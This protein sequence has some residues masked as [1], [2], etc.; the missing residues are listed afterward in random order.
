M[1]SLWYEPVLSA[2]P[3]SMWNRVLSSSECCMVVHSRHKRTGHVK[4]MAMTSNRILIDHLVMTYAISGPAS[5][6]NP[7]AGNTRRSCGHNCSQDA[8][9]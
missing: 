6:T 8:Q 2:T 7:W 4:Q 9:I 1:L 5:I 3:V